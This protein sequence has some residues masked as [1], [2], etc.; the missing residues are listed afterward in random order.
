MS[1]VTDRRAARVLLVDAADRVLLFAGSDPLRPGDGSWWFT[2]GG[3]L[4]DGEDARTRV[5]TVLE[6]EELF[7][8]RAPDLTSTFLQVALAG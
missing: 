4:D 2:P 8:T 5:L 1:T 7:R 6:L 3:G